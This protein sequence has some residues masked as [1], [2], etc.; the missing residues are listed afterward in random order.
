MAFLLQSLPLR[1]AALQRLDC[2]RQWRQFH[3]ATF[4]C[5]CDSRI[6]TPVPIDNTCVYHF[7]FPFFLL[8]VRKRIAGFGGR[9]DG[10]PPRV[11]RL[12]NRFINWVGEEKCCQSG[13]GDVTNWPE[14]PRWL[15][16]SMPRRGKEAQ[17]TH[18]RPL[19]RRRRK[20]NYFFEL[21]FDWRDGERL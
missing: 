20:K 6:F 15:M 16:R 12:Y 14:S 19:K 10:T 21:P 13:R 17:N 8:K 11:G 1:N 7:F 2:I 9:E 5:V 18:T 3:V 4:F